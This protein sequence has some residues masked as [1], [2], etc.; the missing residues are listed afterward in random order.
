[1]P[2]SQTKTIICPK[3]NELSF[4]ARGSVWWRWRQ[5]KTKQGNKDIH[6]TI[7]FVFIS[8]PRFCMMEPGCCKGVY[9]IKNNANERL[10]YIKQNQKDPCFGCGTRTGDCCKRIKDDCCRRPDPLSIAA[11]VLRFLLLIEYNLG[12]LEYCIIY[13]LFCHSFFCICCTM[14]FEKASEKLQFYK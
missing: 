9:V 3:L 13:W 12:I 14:K 1:M 10:F 7:C 6:L 11:E 8:S 5:N 4:A 2:I